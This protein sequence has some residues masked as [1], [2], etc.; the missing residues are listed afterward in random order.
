MK[1]KLGKKIIL[2]LTV[3]IVIFSLVACGGGK[4]DSSAYKADEVKTKL[5]EA[6]EI[7]ES[8]ISETER[9]GTIVLSYGLDG[10]SVDAYIMEDVK[11]A[12][13]YFS[14][15]AMAGSFND[16]RVDENDR[17]IWVSE[18][19]D[20]ISGETKYNTIAMKDN[21]IILDIGSDLTPEDII[22]TFDLGE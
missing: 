13:E 11:S 3:L 7:D 15:P 5:A 10:V 14:I 9:D 16:K 18:I 17:K 12:Q 8:A 1:K 2:L 6:L 4:K 20:M 19:E 22:E 21:F